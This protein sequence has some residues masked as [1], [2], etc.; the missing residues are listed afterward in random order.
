MLAVK[1]EVTSWHYYLS[2][3]P[4]I[5]VT[6]HVPLLLMQW[7]KDTNDKVLQW[8]LALLPFSFTTCHSRGALH[9]NATSPECRPL[10]TPRPQAQGG[11]LLGIA[12]AAC[13]TRATPP[14][15]SCGGTGVS[16]QGGQRRDGCWLGRRS[17]ASPAD[18]LGTARGADGLAATKEDRAERAAV[19]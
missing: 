13:L 3:N 16:A 19:E 9:A 7:L 11:A 5:L 17:W 2:A 12:G 4:F 14:G 1:W 8:H 6:D 15:S 10:T 18:S